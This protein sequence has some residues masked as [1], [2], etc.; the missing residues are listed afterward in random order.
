[1][2]GFTVVGIHGHELVRGDIGFG[3]T[4]EEPA[5]LLDNRLVKDILL[6][7]N[8]S[9]VS[10]A[11]RQVQTL[12]GTMTQDLLVFRGKNEIRALNVYAVLN[13]PIHAARLLVLI[14]SGAKGN[15]ETQRLVRVE[16]VEVRD[17]FGVFAEK[18]VNVREFKLTLNCTFGGIFKVKVNQ[19][20]GLKVAATLLNQVEGSTLL[21][22]EIFVE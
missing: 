8:V 9:G 14:R 3:F 22:K 16:I 4:I 19:D 7:I 17:I 13:R 2:F 1:M 21:R 11:V 6:S 10:K 20:R 15:E 12:N 18:L 5:I